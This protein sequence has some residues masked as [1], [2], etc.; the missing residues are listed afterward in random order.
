MQRRAGRRTIPGTLAQ[1]AVGVLLSLFTGTQCR[2][3]VHRPPRFTLAPGTIVVLTHRRD[4]DIPLLVRALLGP[5]TWWRWPG[6]VAFVATSELYV[7]GF[8]GLYFP[9]LGPLRPWLGRL[10]LRPVLRALR[11][12]PVAQT[13]P[14]LVAAWLDELV[15]VYGAHAP[16]AGL[17][18]A[19]A[20]AEAT[21]A[22]LTLPGTVG[23]ARDP[24]Y[25]DWLARDADHTLLRPPVERHVRM[26]V[27]R[28]AR[29]RLAGLAGELCAGNAV[30]IAPEGNVSPDGTLQR[31]RSGLFR[32]L[33]AA[34]EAVVVPVGITYDL[35]LPGRPTA[36][37]RVGPALSG[38]GGLPRAD[39]ERRVRQALARLSTVTLAQ[40]VGTVLLD[41]T[42]PDVDEIPADA[43]ARRVAARAR[44]LAKA[45]YAVDERLLRRREFTRLWQ[46]FVRRAHR[47]GLLVE[48]GMVRL[49]RTVLMRPV[50]GW[51]DNPLGYARNE[52]R[53]VRGTAL[54]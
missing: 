10:S 12:V 23:A 43:L 30:V 6:R 54:G 50:N 29:A 47:R 11:V 45:G 53:W 5:R 4:L 34:P 40:V 37:V 31:F 2:P 27:T 14:R 44:E 13:G 25:R 3:R 22:G 28:A 51:A 35:L 33:V 52:L 20:L 48:G 17:L 38:L 21:R 24:R 36:F 16:L 49:D 26:A 46:G 8:L 19:A 39:C 41:E 15:A 9:Q 7:T 1:L 18:S 42:A 32:L